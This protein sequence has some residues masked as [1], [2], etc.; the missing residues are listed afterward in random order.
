MDALANLG[1][2]LG[3]L[4]TQIVNL[5][6]MLVILYLVAYK[7]MVRMLRERRERIAEGINN[8]RKAE[9]MLASADADK[10]ALLDEA[11][12]ESQRIV[13]EARSRAEDA[14]DQIKADARQEANRILEQ[15]RQDAVSERNRL[16]A[17][18]R[19]Q[20]VLLS[21]AAASHLLRV[22]L[23]EKMQRELVTDF[24]TRLPAEAKSLDGSLVV[25]TAIPLTGDEQA[26]FKK[27]LGSED[28]TFKT[29]PAILG[30]VVVRAGGREVDGSFASQLESIQADLS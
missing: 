4:I 2:N 20:I 25:L 14:A 7:P 10:Q 23:D 5:L 11:R 8:A 16:L 28:V 6:L 15:A 12:A 22:N 19:D 9:E 30:G 26:R 3:Y 18:M 13:S 17:D 1:I 27:E 21:I 29:D 24:F